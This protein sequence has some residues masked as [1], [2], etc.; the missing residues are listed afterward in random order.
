MLSSAATLP[1]DLGR[2]QTLP[3]PALGPRRIVRLRLAEADL[4]R[5][6]RRG[7][8]GFFVLMP[9]PPPVGTALDCVFVHP[10]SGAEQRLAARVRREEETLAGPGAEIVLEPLDGPGLTRLAAF[11]RGDVV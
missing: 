10:V 1:P 5:C 4:G 2:A 9:D 8:K 11:L 6:L 3:L 7:A